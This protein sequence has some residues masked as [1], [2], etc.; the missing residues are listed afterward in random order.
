LPAAVRKAP[1]AG[2]Q[3]LA[4]PVS[5]S[6]VRCA[7]VV[8]VMLRSRSFESHRQKR[9]K[10]AL[11]T[12]RRLPAQRQVGVY[13]NLVS[14]LR[15]RRAAQAAA[16]EKVV[17]LVTIR[18]NCGLRCLADFLSTLRYG[19]HRYVSKPLIRNRCR[20][21]LL[22]TATAAAPPDYHRDSSRVVPCGASGSA[23]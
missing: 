15:R 17:R 14:D 11:P 7:R 18:K 9:R 2:A 19:Q 5:T 6:L 22:F 20:G 23:Q 4:Q 10:R 8:P 21:V 1:S 12:A 3:S 16:C 13:L